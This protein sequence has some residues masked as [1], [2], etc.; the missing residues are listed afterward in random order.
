MS[1][2]SAFVTVGILA[3]TFVS[4]AHSEIL[5]RVFLA[6]QTM[7]VRVHGVEVY[8]WRVST[9]KYGHETPPGSFRPFWLNRNHYSSLYDWTPMPYA[10]F[11]N[12]NIA[13]HG[14]TALKQLGSRASH[15]CVRLSTQNAKTLFRLVQSYGQQKTLVIVE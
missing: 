10:I 1:I 2:K 14:T 11:F 4:P 9:G 13:I 8:T 6:T 12:G 7:A 3:A 15:G 5:V